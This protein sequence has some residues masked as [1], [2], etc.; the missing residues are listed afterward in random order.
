[1]VQ[2]LF[3]CCMYSSYVLYVSFI[4][5]YIRS[6]LKFMQKRESVFAIRVSVFKQRLAHG[7]LLRYDIKTSASKQ[8][9]LHTCDDLPLEIYLMLQVVGKLYAYVTINA[10]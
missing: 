5:K 4:Y 8:A 9:H 10:N 2:C 3:V 6:V 1:M 7:F